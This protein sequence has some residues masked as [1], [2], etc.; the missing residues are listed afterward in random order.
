MLVGYTTNGQRAFERTAVHEAGHSIAKLLDEYT[1]DLPDIDFPLNWIPVDL[2]PFPNVSASGTNPKWRPWVAPGTPLPTPAGTAG[3][4]LGAYEGASNMIRDLYRPREDCWMRSHGSAFCEVCSE[5]WIKV[6]YEK[7][8]VAD[9]FSPPAGSIVP[10]FVMPTDSVRFSASLVR[11][12]GVGIRT[13]W[14]T[15]RVED[16]TWRRRQRTA[17]YADFTAS[18]PVNMVA[19][20]SLPTAWQ[21]RCV[22]EDR[23]PMLRQRPALQAAT[24]EAVWS[25][26]SSIQPMPHA[27]AIVPHVDVN[28]VP[29][30]D[31]WLIPHGDTGLIGHGDTW[32][33]PHADVSAGGH[34]DTPVIPHADGFLVPHG[35]IPAMLHGDIGFSAH[36]DTPVL[37]HGD[38]GGILH[39]DV[40]IFGL[41]HVDTPSVGHIDTP[42][43]GHADVPGAVHVDTPTVGHVDVAPTAHVDTA[44][45]GHVDVPSVVHLD[46]PPGGHVDTP[47]V[48][49]LDTPTTGHVDTP[50]TAHL[51]VPPWHADAP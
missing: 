45:M 26:V 7:S 18:F 51:D 49:H 3:S 31:T 22:L 39:G 47:E 28:L 21:V 30:G 46:T 16:V 13:S 12:G 6:I 25:V 4:P 42:A 10:R 27:D 35:D 23:S 11:P 33:I 9:S 50:E 14:F 34:G 19:R 2:A 1:G 38:V 20:A 41:A 48:A 40:N 24:Q 15:K 36:I 44:P 29:H 43:L 32:L 37:P 8:P 5:Q 17:D